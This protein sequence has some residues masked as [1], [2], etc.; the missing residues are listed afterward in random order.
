M[1]LVYGVIC[2]SVQDGWR[3]QTYLLCCWLN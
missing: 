1:L 3:L 2:G